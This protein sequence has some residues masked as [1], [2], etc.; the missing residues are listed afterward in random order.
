MSGE[1]LSPDFNTSSD[2]YKFEKNA[3]VVLSVRISTPAATIYQSYDFLGRTLITQNGQTGS[4]PQIT[5]FG[6]L[7][8]ESL[9]FMH[10]K[11]CELGGRPPALPALPQEGQRR[12]L[13][14]PRSEL[15]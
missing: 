2:K 13:A 11:L 15:A 4:S 10:A 6:Q 14:K 3:D 5:P 1:A 7:D 9:E 8:R 12:G